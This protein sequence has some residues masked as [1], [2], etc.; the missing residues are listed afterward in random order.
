[1]PKKVMAL[2]NECPLVPRVLSTCDDTGIA[3]A[4]THNRHEIRLD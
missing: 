4:K 3:S 1:M 2:L